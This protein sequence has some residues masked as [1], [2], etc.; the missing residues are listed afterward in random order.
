MARQ[1]HWKIKEANEVKREETIRLISY[2][3][4]ILRLS[5]SVN[6]ISPLLISSVQWQLL[7]LYTS[8]VPSVGSQGLL[9]DTFLLQESHEKTQ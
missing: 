4:I 5:T 2:V 9:N 7:E 3:E 6:L 8:L 1:S